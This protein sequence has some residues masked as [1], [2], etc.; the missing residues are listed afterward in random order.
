MKYAFY[1]GETQST[2]KALKIC[3]APGLLTRIAEGTRFALPLPTSLTPPPG[4]VAS[5]WVSQVM[6]GKVGEAQV[7]KTPP[8]PLPLEL[9]VEG[10]WGKRWWSASGRLCG[11]VCV[12][13]PHSLSVSHSVVL[14]QCL[15]HWLVYS[16]DRWR[17]ETSVVK[18][19]LGW[20]TTKEGFCIHR[21]SF[22]LLR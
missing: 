22:R 10:G 19:G 21:T 3:T 18:K 15:D 5:D 2:F 6:D 1:P 12:P 7:A 8:P 11:C 17:C 13:V 16:K 20:M 9:Q 14:I 4:R